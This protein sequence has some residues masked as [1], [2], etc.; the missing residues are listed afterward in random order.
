MKR[1]PNARP[2]TR[3]RLRQERFRLARRTARS[4]TS[5]RR[6]K[7]TTKTEKAPAKDADKPPKPTP[8]R[9]RKTSRP[10]PTAKD[11]TAKPE[12]KPAAKADDK[13]GQAGSKK[14]K[15][16]KVEPKRLKVD[17]P[18]DG[19]FVARKMEEVALRPEAWTEY[20]IV[21]VVEHGA[22]VHKG[23]ALFKFDAEKINEAIARP[24]TG[25][26]A[27]RAGDRA[28]PKKNC[29]GWKRRSRWISRTPTAPTANAKEDFKRYNE[30]DRPMTVKSAEFMVKYY[31]F[32][33][34]YEK[35]ELDQLE[36]MYKADDLT[37]ETEEIVLKRQRNAVEFA[38]FS[39]E[40]AKL[41]SDE[42]L[43]IR[44]PRMDIRMKESLDRAALAKA[45]AK[46][47]CRST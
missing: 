1:R 32:M 44:L 6:P 18:L 11:K 7:P 16:Y 42:M 27:Q 8:K 46:W 17:V 14:R 36:K 15:T 24:G 31:D 30:I 34:D 33:L 37:E 26:A 43:N 28:R 41:N 5:R 39:L 13:A 19:T 12:E 20:E 47:R 2:P 45:R 21:D 29:R 3:R 25:T 10:K 9:R 4:P 35:D 40:N 23:E 22:K 38:E